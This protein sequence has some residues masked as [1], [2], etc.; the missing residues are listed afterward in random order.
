M[1]TRECQ[2]EEVEEVEARAERIVELE[3]RLEE[4]KKEDTVDGDYDDEITLDFDQGGVVR[5]PVVDVEEK[6]GYTHSCAITVLVDDEE[7]TFRI[8]WPADTTD[9]TEELVR[10]CRWAGVDVERIGDIEEVPL[11]ERD[12]MRGY[13]L[14]IPPRKRKRL[15]NIVLP[16]GYE[17]SFSYTPL[18]DRFHRLM[19]RMAIPLVVTPLLAPTGRKGFVPNE[20]A[21]TVGAASLTTL[22]SFAT[23]VYLANPISELF[24]LSAVGAFAFLWMVYGFMIGYVGVGVMEYLEECPVQFRPE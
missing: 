10:L 21:W 18:S 12:G 5:A 3:S 20:K 23:L 19:A 24:T 15:F 9:R 7:K 4:A 11:V 2:I 16:R 8:D 6:N 17:T 22:V 13:V 14:L 1:A